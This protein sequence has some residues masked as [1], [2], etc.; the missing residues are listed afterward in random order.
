MK[1]EMTPEM[2]EAHDKWQAGCDEIAKLHVKVGTLAETFN[3]MKEAWWQENLHSFNPDEVEDMRELGRAGWDNG[4]G[5]S[6]I[7]EYLREWLESKHERLSLNGWQ[8]ATS[9][10]D[11]YTDFL[12]SISLYV[13]GHEKGEFF[14][15]FVEAL[16]SVAQL[17]KEASQRDYVISVMENSLSAG[18]TYYIT[19]DSKGVFTLGKRT[20]GRE[21]EIRSGTAEEILKFMQTDVV[22]CDCQK[23]RPEES[24]S[25]Y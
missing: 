19:R 7:T 25:W 8:N 23:H 10:R 11:N 17:M 16:E 21:S 13:T 18:G 24:D 14:E 12:P 5:N 9:D 4:S 2:V 20:Y 6:L 22:Y 3:G 1:F 15:A